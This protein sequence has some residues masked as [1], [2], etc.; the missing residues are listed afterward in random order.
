MTPYRCITVLQSRALY[1]A[2]ASAGEILAYC[3]LY[4][5]GGTNHLCTCST[6]F[7]ASLTEA[8]GRRMNPKSVSRALNSLAKKEYTRPDGSTRPVLG[9]IG[10]SGYRGHTATYRDNLEE[11]WGP[12]G[13]VNESVYQ[14]IRERSTNPFPKVNESV[15]PQYT[16]GA[17]TAKPSCPAPGLRRL[18]ER[19]TDYDAES[20]EG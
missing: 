16:K 19:Q 8:Q 17:T 13:K 18:R 2:K 6:E 1:E 5:I 9:K 12:D 10:A 14:S 3:M 11:D 20:E 7:V 4:P 15:D